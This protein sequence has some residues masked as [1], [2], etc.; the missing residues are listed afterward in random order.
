MTSVGPLVGSL[1]GHRAHRLAPIRCQHDRALAP[2]RDPRSLRQPQGRGRPPA[3][4][5]GAAGVRPGTGDRPPQPPGR[6]ATDPGRRRGD[7]GPRR[8][9]AGRRAPGAPDRPGAQ[10]RRTRNREP[11]GE[12]RV[13]RHGARRRGR[14]GPGRLAGP[15]RSPLGRRRG[16]GGGTARGPGH[17]ARTDPHGAQRAPGDGRPQGR[18]A[19]RDLRPAARRAGGRRRRP[20]QRRDR[21]P[22]ATYV[23]GG[24][25]MSPGQ[26]LKRLGFTNAQ[27]STPVRDLSGG[28]RR[29]LQLLLVLLDEPNVLVLDEPTNDMDTDMLAA[30]EDLLDSWPGTLLVVSHDRYLLEWVTDQ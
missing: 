12:P 21:G 26:L 4:R 16:P 10:P 5:A 23:A 6:A 25:E 9:A 17:R 14:G 29:R 20:G 19:A 27:L 2:G 15:P 3:R 30:M 8:V 24:Q 13:L 28:Q 7:R 18:V 1:H 22:P 11:G